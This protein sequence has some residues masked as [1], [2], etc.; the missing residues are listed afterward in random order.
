MIRLECRPHGKDRRVRLHDI[1]PGLVDELNEHDDVRD[2]E[3]D[4]LPDL[5]GAAGSGGLHMIV[6]MLRREAAAVWSAEGALLTR[7]DM[8]YFFFWLLL[9]KN[10][11]S[12]NGTGGFVKTI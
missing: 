7:L 5:R 9:A 8:A 11:I 10:I 4:H 6:V 3:R 2:A 1:G 12:C